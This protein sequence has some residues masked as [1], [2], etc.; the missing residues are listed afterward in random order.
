M[1]SIACSRLA[2]AADPEPGHCQE[3]R[4]EAHRAEARDIEQQARAEPG[5]RTERGTAQERDGEQQDEQEVGRAAKGRP[6]VQHRD[7]HE[8]CDEEQYGCLQRIHQCFLCLTT[9]FGTRTSTD[10]SDDSPAYGCT[11]ICL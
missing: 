2:V 3:E 7:L 4:R 10:C 8:H 11:W 5:D 9:G 6:A 1:E